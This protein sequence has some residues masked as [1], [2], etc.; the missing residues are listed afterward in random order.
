MTDLEA[1][2]QLTTA[3]GWLLLADRVRRYWTDTMD[4]HLASAAND[5]NDGIAVQKI[6]QVLAAKAAAEQ[7]LAIPHEEMRR[8]EAS[9]AHAQ[10]TQTLAGLYSRRGGL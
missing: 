4:Q 8:L 9:S 3:P 10:D 2:Q 1:Y 7:V 5:P 6:R